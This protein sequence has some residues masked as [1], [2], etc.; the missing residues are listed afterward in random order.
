MDLL[1]MKMTSPRIR[2]F[3]MQCGYEYVVIYKRCCLSW[4]NLLIWSCNRLAYGLSIQVFNKSCVGHLCSIWVVT[5][6]VSHIICESHVLASLHIAFILNLYVPL[7]IGKIFC[8][9]VI[10]FVLKLLLYKVC[11]EECIILKFERN[12]RE[13][14]IWIIMALCNG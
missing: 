1:W 12:E 2:A 6:W 13:C 5:L 9:H 8:F 10:E 14:P 4:K 7:T 11:F 3:G